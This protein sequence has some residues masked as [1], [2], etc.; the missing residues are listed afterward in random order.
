MQTQITA[1]VRT[2]IADQ[3]FDQ[4]ALGLKTAIEDFQTK[5]SPEALTRVLTALQPISDFGMKFWGTTRVFVSRH[6]VQ[7]TA[8][9][10]G[11]VAAGYMLAQ[12][13]KRPNFVSSDKRNY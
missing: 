8:A 13:A 6:P 7:T 5:Q 3:G 12:Y 1:P 11:L 9:V 10:V 4:I 2:R